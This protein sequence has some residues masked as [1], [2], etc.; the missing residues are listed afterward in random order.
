MARQFILIDG[1]LSDLRHLEDG[2][3]IIVGLIAKDK[4]IKNF[5]GLDGKDLKNLGRFQ[6][7]CTFLNK[8]SS[9]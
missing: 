5:N 1:D 3:K 9:F 6:I 4:A 7:S 8:A 2:K